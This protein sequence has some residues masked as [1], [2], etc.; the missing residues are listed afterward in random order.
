LKN[1]IKKMMK[2]RKKKRK[3]LY[4]RAYKRIT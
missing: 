4:D 3:W 1:I 2:K